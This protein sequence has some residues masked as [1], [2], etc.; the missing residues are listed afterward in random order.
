MPNKPT[1]SEPQ[2]PDMVADRPES[3]KRTAQEQDLVATELPTPEHSGQSGGD[4]ARDVGTRDNRRRATNGGKVVT[5]VR[6]SDET[7]ED[8]PPA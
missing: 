5:R 2:E 8:L 7:D 3:A 4:L 6:K 1:D